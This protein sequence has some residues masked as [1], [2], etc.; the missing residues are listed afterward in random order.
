M[1]DAND[2]AN[3]SSHRAILASFENAY[4]VALRLRRET[5]RAQFI[6]RT[7]NPMQPFRTTANPPMSNETL[8]ALIV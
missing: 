4:L 5:G 2:M 3:L 1:P 7:G 8:L 6:L